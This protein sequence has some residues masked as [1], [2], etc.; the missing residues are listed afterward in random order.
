MFI[1]TSDEKSAKMLIDR[2]QQKLVGAFVEA[3]EIEDEIDGCMAQETWE[4]VDI[5]QIFRDAIAS[6]DPKLVLHLE[7]DSRVKWDRKGVFFPHGLEDMY[8]GE[9]DLDDKY[10]DPMVSIGSVEVG[11]EAVW[12]SYREA[13]PD[14][15]HAEWAAHCKPL[16]ADGYNHWKD[17]Y[18]GEEIPYT[19]PVYAEK[20][21]EWRSTLAQKV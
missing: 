10:G 8:N 1:E 4:L 19:D 14:E 2:L 6:V 5:E 9:I 11:I 16:H 17:T 20:F 12:G 15:A 3:K 7:Y 21:P 13:F 18:D